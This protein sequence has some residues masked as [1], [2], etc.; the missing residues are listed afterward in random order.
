V[1]P[2]VGPHHT[3]RACLFAFQPRFL[4]LG[5]FLTPQPEIKDFDFSS[6]GLRHEVSDLEFFSQSQPAVEARSLAVRGVQ[7]A[8]LLTPLLIRWLSNPELHTSS[9]SA[10]DNVHPTPFSR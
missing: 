8:A 9:A 5:R 7:D 3:K 6:G 4:G 2:L 1:D 10:L